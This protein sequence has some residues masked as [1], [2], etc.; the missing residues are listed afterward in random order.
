MNFFNGDAVDARFGV[1]QG[2]ED[3]RSVLPGSIGQSGPGDQ[4]E[5]VMKMTVALAG[6]RFDAE[7]RGGE[8][9]APCF[10]R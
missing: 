4:V 5:N 9:A 7:F 10:S 8:A 3:G 1:G 6:L 2:A